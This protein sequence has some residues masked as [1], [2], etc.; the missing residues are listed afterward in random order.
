MDNNKPW[1]RA[2]DIAKVLGY[3]NTAKAISQHITNIDNKQKFEEL[4]NTETG[5]T[6]YHE[7]NRVHK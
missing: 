5:I 3:V 4:V 6:D 2:K 7:K 1:F